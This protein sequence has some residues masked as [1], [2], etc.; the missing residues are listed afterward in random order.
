MPDQ[1]RQ[2]PGIAC[3]ECRKRKL[4][5]DRGRP[6]C[7]TCFNS[8]IECVR[9]TARLPRGP[10]K[11]FLKDLRAHI[12]TLEQK[13]HEQTKG[14]GESTSNTQD[15]DDRDD[16]TGQCEKGELN[17]HRRDSSQSH[18]SIF[19]V[20]PDSA[21]VA[22]PLP[23]PAVPWGSSGIVL[24][25]WVKGDLDQLYFDRAHP[26][27]PI[28]NKS[29]YFSW[30]STAVETTRGGYRMCLQKA[31]W[32]LAMA[33][34]TQFESMRESLYQETR[35]MLE[36]REQSE[37]DMFNLHLEQL[38]AWILI[39]HYEFLRS[40]YRRA[41]TSAGRVF[42]LVHLLRL[43][44]VDGPQV[45]LMQALQASTDDNIK[46]EEQRRAFWTSYCLDRFVSL[47]NRLP[48]TLNENT[49]SVCLPASELDFQS[50]NPV[51]GCFLSESLMSGN[52]GSFSQLAE[53]AQAST[54]C[55][56]AFS[57]TNMCSIDQLLS[58]DLKDFW[59]QHDW[60]DNLLATRVAGFSQKYSSSS[61]YADPLLLQTQVLWHTTTLHLYSVMEPLTVHD[62]SAFRVLEYQRK[63]GTAAREIA[64]IAK[65]YAR[66]GAF[67]AHIFMPVAIFLAAEYFAAQQ[68][69]NYLS[70]TTEGQEQGPEVLKSELSCCIE[71][72]RTVSR[73]NHL[74]AHYLT[75]LQPPAD[76]VDI[77]TESTGTYSGLDL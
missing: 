76:L 22:S 66:P 52:Y 50:G 63:A 7:E 38:Q 49:I 12:Q 17:A 24:N 23:E 4:R 31:M 74:A 56:R 30:A 77:E 64:S 2:Q 27:V 9:T 35:Q 10:R 70:S 72:L 51:R 42:R 69:S 47:N 34:S 41:W 43:H 68:H 26:I 3:D 67:K 15:Q 60:V 54:I 55:G 45:S 20:I 33:M 21:G 73:V 5:C 44:E 57:H 59:D 65:N 75:L 13:L 8:G 71:A 40:S 1:P 6:K 62:Q 11:G 25:E 39:T 32:T 29:R 28:L 36:E 53:C 16:T 48:L 46:V 18:S 58:G 19:N 14:D 61:I 37:H